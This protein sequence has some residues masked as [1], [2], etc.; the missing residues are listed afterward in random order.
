VKDQGLDRIYRWDSQQKTLQRFRW[1]A[2]V[3]PEGFPRPARGLQIH[4]EA[5]ACLLANGPS[6]WLLPLPALT[7]EEP[8]KTGKPTQ[9][10]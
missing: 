10:K 4:P 5:G 3:T 6:A 9:V 1:S 7:L 8:T 2:L